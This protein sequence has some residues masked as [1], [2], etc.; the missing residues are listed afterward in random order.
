VTPPIFS[1]QGPCPRPPLTAARPV[2]TTH[3]AITTTST[4]ALQNGTRCPARCRQP[5][6]EGAPAC[7]CIDPGG[8][9]LGEGVSL[10]AKQRSAAPP[11]NRGPTPRGLRGHT[12]S[13]HPQL[14]GATCS[15]CNCQPP[16]PQDL[17]SNR[18][19][20]G[21]CD[22]RRHHDDLDVSLA[23]WNSMLRP[24][25]RPRKVRLRIDPCLWLW[26][27]QPSA[28][29]GALAGATCP[30]HPLPNC[31]DCQAPRQPSGRKWNIALGPDLS[32]TASEDWE[33]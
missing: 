28:A 20:P 32:H 18:R 30:S 33:A 11:K 24:L 13:A 1:V 29:T 31:T 8:W 19:T 12:D 27:S 14:A 15:P 6:S 9:P 3:V 23:E 25:G 5:R 17:P 4:S 16:H 7:G 2:G 22:P 21:Q 26:L 10:P